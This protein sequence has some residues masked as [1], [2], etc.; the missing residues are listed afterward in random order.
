MSLRI[1]TVRLDYV[2]TERETED[3]PHPRPAH[4]TRR[5]RLSSLGFDTSG[6]DND[7]ICSYPILGMTDTQFVELTIAGEKNMSVLGSVII[8]TSI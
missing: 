7:A 5:D 6:I 3:N 2:Y 4:E 8:E 1:L